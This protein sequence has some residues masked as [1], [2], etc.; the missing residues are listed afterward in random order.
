MSIRTVLF[1]LDGTLIDTNE[2][3]ITSFDYTFKKY[4]ITLTKEEIM[5]FNGP[6]LKDTFK[7][8]DPNRWEDMLETYREH[9][10]LHHDQHVEIYPNVMETIKQLKEKQIKLAI[11]TTK[12][13]TGAMM[14]LDLTK[15]TPFF[16]SIITFDDVVHAKPHPEPVLK[17]MNEL[18]GQVES[19]LMVGDN[20]HDIEAGRRAGVRTA[21]VAWAAKGREY[22]ESYNP[23]YMFEDMKDVL[24]LI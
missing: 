10:L 21:G 4:G 24:Q 11:V 15:L 23:T 1:D 9:N 6:P 14:G 8:V 22:L 16:E 19:T 12:M 17:A 3:I 2:L 18:G 5:T 7:K 13:R 20:Y